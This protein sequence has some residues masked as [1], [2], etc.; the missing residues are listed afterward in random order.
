MLNI[1]KK[2][3]LLLQTLQ[4]YYSNN[5]NLKQLIT[6]LSKECH[7]SLRILDYLC[8]NYAKTHDIVYNVSNRKTPFNIYLQYK[9]QLKA[10]SKLQ[11]DPFKRHERITI[12]VPKTLVADGSIDTTIA[13]LN[14]FRWAIQNKVIDYLKDA[15]NFATVEK[16]MNE[17]IKKKTTTKSSS[18]ITKRQNIHVTVTFA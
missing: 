2:G 11:F 13:Q 18:V 10:Y 6:L 1:E 17:N 3:D 12:A 14:F 5:S 4:K 16:A 15:S 9:A 8:T 7:I